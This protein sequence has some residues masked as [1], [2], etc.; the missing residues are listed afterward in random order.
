MGANGDGTI[1]RILLNEVEQSAVVTDGI[2]DDLGG[3]D[4]AAANP[5][6]IIDFNVDV[7]PA[8]D[9]GSDGTAYGFTIETVPEPD[10]SMLLFLAVP[11]RASPKKEIDETEFR[12]PSVIRTL[13][14]G[15]V[16][17]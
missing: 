15:Q 5:E 3:G 12:A 13:R 6:D 4:F 11:S 9:D 17:G 14:R 16:G 7:G 2:S 1:D 10:S 8:E